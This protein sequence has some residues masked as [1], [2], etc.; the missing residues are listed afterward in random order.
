MIPFWEV[1]MKGTKIV[2]P[3]DY[4][5]RVFALRRKFRLTQE[6][7]AD[8]LNVSFASVNRWENGQNRPTRS[9]WMRIMRL[10]EGNPPLPP[11]EPSPWRV[12]PD[13]NDRPIRIN[14]A[15]VVSYHQPRECEAATFHP[16]YETHEYTVL[17]MNG[18]HRHYL[19]MCE[20]E[21]DKIFG[22]DSRWLPAI[23]PVAER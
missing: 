22:V 8:R 19:H 3:G 21:L 9:A 4:P 5:E 18:G 13:L 17:Y 1:T 12:L 10:A 11:S 16:V 20:V 14:I 23:V 6:Q 15:Q 7:F 2:V